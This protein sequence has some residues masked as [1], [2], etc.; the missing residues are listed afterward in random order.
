MGAVRLVTTSTTSLAGYGRSLVSSSTVATAV[1]FAVSHDGDPAGNLVVRL[2]LSIL[3]SLER[4][5]SREGI[6]I[7]VLG[8]N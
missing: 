8:R 5:G 6:S 1:P 3:A 4:H 7:R 2:E